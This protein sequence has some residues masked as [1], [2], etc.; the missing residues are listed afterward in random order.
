MTVL[1]FIGG[2]VGVCSIVLWGLFWVK[3]WFNV[4]KFR[5]V[6]IDSLVFPE[7]NQW[8]TLCVIIAACN[9]AGRIEAA[10]RSLLNQDYPKLELVFVD[11]RSEDETGE[12]IDRLAAAD[13]RLT[14]IHID[15]LPDGW[16][17]KVHALHIAMEQTDSE[18]VL[19]TDADVC[20]EEGALRQII[21][22]G[23][24]H[25]ADHLAGLPEIQ[26]AGPLLDVA[27]STFFMSS[28]FFVTPS[29]VEDP[30][31]SMAVGVGACNL[32]R[33][34]RF[35]ETPG[36]TWLKMETA[37]DLGLGLMMKR[38]GGRAQVVFA[39]AQ[40]SL[41]WYSSIGEMVRGLEKNSPGLTHYRYG[42]AIGMVAVFTG[43]LVAPLGLLWVP[44]LV[45]IVLL[46]LLSLVAV[47]SS[48]ALARRTC[49]SRI[50]FMLAPIGFA[51]LAFIFFRA[52]LLLWFRGG[53][54]WRGTKYDLRSLRQGQRIEF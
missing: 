24:A 16:L 47:V 42:R 4:G 19:F 26:P 1:S 40:L 36:F 17:G 23:V 30:N 9:E 38:W 5:C 37:D 29:R 21:S 8:P 31:D 12:I 49:F 45:A 43:C 18:W 33:R 20:F 11:D 14:A 34:T 53:V 27:I 15:E 7:P 3:A 28:M 22:D 25:R 46:V 10:A 35:E 51:I 39:Q 2:A 32:V 6:Q 50:S 48:G 52:C 13:A 54:V 41:D 44:Q